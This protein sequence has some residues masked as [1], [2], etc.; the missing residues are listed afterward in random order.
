MYDITYICILHQKA[1]HKN[2]LTTESHCL[3]TQ[4][5]PNLA[6]HCANVMADGRRHSL[7]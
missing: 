3:S 2:E 6:V 1:I 4:I 7:A 5:P